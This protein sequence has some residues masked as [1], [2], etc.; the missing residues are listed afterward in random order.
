VVVSVAVVIVVAAVVDDTD[1]V[2]RW[3]A[4]DAVVVVALR[5]LAFDVAV[6]VVVVVTD[7]CWLWLCNWGRIAGACACDIGLFLHLA[8]FW[9]R[10]GGF[11]Q[12][13]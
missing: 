3:P 12:I 9:F 2:A 4:F 8:A 11:G 1:V 7:L 5:R 13:W 10:F 6:G